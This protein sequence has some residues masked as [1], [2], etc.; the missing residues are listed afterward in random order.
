[1]GRE[2]KERWGARNIDIDILFYGSNIIDSKELTVPHP[3][4]HLRNFVLLPMCELN[5]NWVHPVLKKN[6]QTL[7]VECTD[8]LKAKLI[9]E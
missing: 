3:R 9:I 2:R 4:L 1:M 8:T 5:P 7:L 6:M